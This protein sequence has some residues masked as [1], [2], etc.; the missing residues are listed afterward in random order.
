MQCNW[1]GV[2]LA[3][4]MRLFFCRRRCSWKIVVQ[5]S[6]KILSFLLFVHCSYSC[7]CSCFCSFPRFWCFNFMQNWQKQRTT[8]LWISFFSK[9]LCFKQ[10]LHYL[11][12]FVLF[13]CKK[14]EMFFFIKSILLANCDL[15]F[16]YID[17]YQQISSK[18][19]L[20]TTCNSMEFSAIYDFIWRS[21]FA[22]YSHTPIHSNRR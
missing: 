13:Y 15:L 18:I 8:F 6:R 3:S 21:L 9:S 17:T 11:F 10:L 14:V 2:L 5:D 19:F 7:C 12:C 16:C 20:F 4:N 22:L 1:G